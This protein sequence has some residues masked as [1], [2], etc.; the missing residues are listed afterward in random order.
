MTDSHS[1]VVL[2]LRDVT[3][4][5][6]DATVLRNVTLSVPKGKAVALLGPNGAGKTTLLRVATGI[7]KPISGR[8]HFDGRDVTKDDTA[9][10]AKAGLCHIPEGRGIFGSL[11]VKENLRLS[12]RGFDVAESIER[13]V[14]A[15]PR[16]GDRL[17]QTA[18][19]MSGGEQQMLA[20]ARAYVTNPLVVLVDEASMGLAPVVVD[21]V[22]E[23]LEK[24]DCSL[25]LVEQYV[26]R[27]LAV[28]DTAYLLSGGQVV[29]AGP[30]S[31]FDAATIFEKYLSIE[32]DAPA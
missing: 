11:S 31:S 25:L 16:L 29:D 12:A 1:E 14:Y 23:F 13:A 6:G 28:V 32:V 5:Y 17:S 4:G 22:F 27:A 15:F 20:L 2:E 3:A 30:A 7:I 10:I 8:V 19:T 26:T 9:T 24:L 21:A 18:G